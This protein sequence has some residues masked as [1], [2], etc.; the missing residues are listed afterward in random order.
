M[1]NYLKKFILNYSRI[2]YPLRRLTQE[3][4]SLEW[5]DEWKE[6]FSQLRSSLSEGSCISYFDEYKEKII[7][8][9]ASPVDISTILLQNSTG[10]N[11]KRVAGAGGAGGQGAMTP[12]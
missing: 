11:N 8:C 10:K 4:I 9:D 7:S 12:Q 1:T 6:V 5:S 2:T 3:D